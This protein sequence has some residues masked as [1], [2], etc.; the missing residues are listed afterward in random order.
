[1]IR[2]WFRDLA[3]KLLS[4]CHLDA[5]TRLKRRLRARPRLETLEDRTLTSTMTIVESFAP[6]GASSFT[7]SAFQYHLTI[8][9][10]SGDPATVSTNNANATAT[11]LGSL[12]EDIRMLDMEA[13]ETL[14]QIET[15][16][17][18]WALDAFSDANISDG[19][20]AY[21]ADHPEFGWSNQPLTVNQI[22]VEVDGVSAADVLRPPTDTH[23]HL[24]T[25]NPANG[26][27]SNN[28]GGQQNALDGSVRLDKPKTQP[29]LDA[30]VISAANPDQRP[31]S[32]AGQPTAAENRGFPTDQSTNSLKAAGS[33][34]PASFESYQTSPTVLSAPQP[35]PQNLDL[36]R[37]ETDAAVPESRQAVPVPIQAQTELK[38]SPADL[39]D[40]ML[41]ERFVVGQK[42]EAFTALVQRYEG[43]VLDI[44]QGVLGDSHTA[45]DAF[46]AT[47]LV[48]A[49]KANLVDGQNPL[50]AWLYKVAYH[51][52]LRLRAVAAR[53]RRRE[54]DAATDRPSSE[55]SECTAEIE[56]QELCLALNEELQRL[57][58]KYRRPLILCYFE[59]RTHEEAA[60][61]IGMP[62]GSMAKRIGEGLERLRERLLERGFIP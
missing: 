30:N 15:A 18:G 23:D 31:S 43:F 10:S 21:K 59:G 49:R 26:N 50:A 25:I 62:R 36:T 12:L 34:H 29:G 45:Q 58:E 3:R 32:Q 24:L 2:P 37:S 33:A 52:A 7:Q 38:G 22:T 54:K 44:C 47:F 17:V 61:T 39:S 19:A 5:E 28:S 40:G 53:Q 1:M 16:Q 27:N 60:Q 4:S 9:I 55:P 11:G 48:L 51:V 41:L 57:P 35:G 46:Q 56:K 14:S 8:H 20:T 42:Q 6:L 13:P